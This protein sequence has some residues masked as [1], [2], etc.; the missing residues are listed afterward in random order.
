[1]MTNFSFSVS[2]QIQFGPGVSRQVGAV[3]NS[4][5]AARDSAS[6]GGAL[7]VVDPGIRSASWLKDILASIGESGL[8]R[9]SVV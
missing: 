5:V 8:D 4:L 2:T 3:T 1:M 7:V 9:K 6:A